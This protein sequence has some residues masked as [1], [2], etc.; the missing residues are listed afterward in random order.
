MSELAQPPGDRAPPAWGSDAIVALLRAA[1]VPYVALNPGSSLRGIHDSLVHVRD[2]GRPE[3]LLCLHEEH[4]VAIAHG[5]AKVTGRPMAAAVHT[6]VGLM[7]AS[8]AIYNA[9]CDRAPLLVLCG[10]GPLDEGLRKPWIDWIHATRDPGALVRPFVKFDALPRSLPDALASLATAIEIARA[11]PPGPAYVCVETPIQEAPIAGM[12]ALPQVG[13][14]PLGVAVPDADAIGEASVLLASTCRPVILAG[15]VSRDEADWERRVQLAELLGARVITDIKAAAAFPTEHPLHVSGAGFFLSAEGRRVLA[16]ADV[17]LAL[18]WIDLA[19]TLG[20]AFPDGAHPPL[21]VAAPDA[22]DR[23]GSAAV[24]H[25]VVADVA[26]A[27]PADRAVGGLLDRLERM[28]GASGSGAVRSAAQA[29]REPG[30]GSERTLSVDD[31]SRGIQA[32]SAG[33]PVCLVRVPIGWHADTWP[34][35]HPLDYIGYDGGAGIGSGPGMA[36]GAALALRGT[37]RLPVAILG[38]GDLLMGVQAL[39]TAV[40]HGIPL[41]VVVANNRSYLSDVAQQERIAVQRGRD[42]AVKWI[43]QRIADPAV[44][45]AG[46]ARAQGL[47]AWGPVASRAELGAALEAAVA[48]VRAGGSALVDVLVDIDPV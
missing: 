18:D 10:S 11:E 45:L 42:P 5:Y 37:D 17:V 31:I 8:M 3:L 26:I 21:V 30:P 12:L 15:R 29:S 4:A 48:A 25:E 22:S 19:G 39:W 2:D 47:E 6:N 27:R 20:Q 9:W 40:H 44:D 35:R 34:F 36:V 38:D 23:T 41:L 16:G 28:P 43:G 13:S 32:A 46:I 14:T 7:H 1:G 24:F 33:S